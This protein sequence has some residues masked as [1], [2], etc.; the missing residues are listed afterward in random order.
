LNTG[1]NVLNSV[2]VNN[3]GTFMFG[4][5]ASLTSYTIQ[6]ST[7][8]G[9]KGQAAPATALPTNWLNTGENLGNGTGS[10][11]LVNSRLAVTM[12]SANINNAN[13][14][15]EQAPDSD[16]K[17]Y[18]I[19]TPARNSFMYLIGLGTIPGALSGADAEDGILG[20]SKRVGITSLPTGGNQLWYNGAQITK[21]ADSI[22]APS[23]SNPFIISSYVLNILAVKFTGAGSNE[24]VFNYAYYDAA[25]VMDGTPATYTINWLS[26]LPVKLVSFTATLNDNHTDLKWTTMT[27]NNLSH[28]AVEKSTDG[29]NFSQAGV[30]FASG[31]T[32]E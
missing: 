14:A 19:P 8:Q 12:A 15:I 30:V 18:G 20:S 27:E 17:W 32:T 11:G 4:N 22:N 28:Y 7:T 26:L 24:T 23:P 1:G 3:D 6:I 13:F 31:N 2:A 10:D 29:K 25:G 21:G 5:V 9:T 16:S